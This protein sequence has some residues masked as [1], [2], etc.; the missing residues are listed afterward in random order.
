MS[1]FKKNCISLAALI[2]SIFSC[3]FTYQQ[4]SL[5]RNQAR[6]HLKPEIT[7]YVDFPDSEGLSLLIANRGNIPAVSL[8]VEDKMFIFEKGSRTITIGMRSQPLLGPASVFMESLKPNDRKRIMLPIIENPGN[9]IVVYEISMRYFR[10]SDMEEF[11]KTDY[12]FYEDGQ[13]YTHEQFRN[14]RFYGDIMAGIKR[15]DFAIDKV[16]D[17]MELLPGVVETLGKN[18]SK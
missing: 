1:F 15:A 9:K 3:L 14:N 12:Y 11:S 10:E 8:G 7:S 4:C 13:R 2:I 5:A 16:A 6:L 17:K 18:S